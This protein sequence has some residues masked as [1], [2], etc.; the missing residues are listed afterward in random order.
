LNIKIVP[1]DELAGADLIVDAIY[2]GGTANNAA[3]F[4]HQVDTREV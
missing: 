1:F 4:R 3:D 2:L